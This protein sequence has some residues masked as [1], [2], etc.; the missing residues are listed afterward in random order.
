MGEEREEKQ[1]GS[2]RI[3]SEYGPH[4]TKP[5]KGSWLMDVAAPSV[6]KSNG[7]FK[8]TYY[9]SLPQALQALKAIH[10]HVTAA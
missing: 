7:V 10:P 9:S 5:G 2:W 8:T 4:E 1:R 3:T 6:E